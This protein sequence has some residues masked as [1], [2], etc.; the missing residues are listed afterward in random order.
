MAQRWTL[1]SQENGQVIAFAELEQDGHLDMFYC[2]CNAVGYGVDR[3][4]FQAIELKA[5]EMGVQR[6]FANV[7]ITVRSFFDRRG[8]VVKRT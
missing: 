7:S 1:V 4:F 8:F 5:I 2:H 6:N 3:P